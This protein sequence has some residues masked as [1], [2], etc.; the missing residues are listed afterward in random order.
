MKYLMYMQVDDSS[1]QLKNVEIVGSS[2]PPANSDALGTL[3]QLD[4]Q[5]GTAGFVIRIQ[6]ILKSVREANSSRNFPFHAVD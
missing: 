6:C 5:L 3:C 4:A 2:K 1:F